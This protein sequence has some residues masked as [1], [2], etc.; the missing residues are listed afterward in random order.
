MFG[1]EHLSPLCDEVQHLLLQ[2]E[3]LQHWAPPPFTDFTRL[4]FSYNE[5]VIPT[6][7]D[8][9]LYLEQGYSVKIQRGP[10]HETGPP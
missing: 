8:N 5:P 10:V 4:F 3:V 2:E 1:L 9:C 6:D 7:D